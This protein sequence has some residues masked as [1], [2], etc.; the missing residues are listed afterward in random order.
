M[1]VL[2]SQNPGLTFFENYDK[3]KTKKSDLHNQTDVEAP[4]IRF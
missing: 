2:I 1:V 4:K 3:N